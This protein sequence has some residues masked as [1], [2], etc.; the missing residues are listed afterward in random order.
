[1]TPPIWDHAVPL[2]DDWRRSGFVIPDRALREQL[3]YEISRAIKELLE[4]E[5]RIDRENSAHNE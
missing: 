4:L 5:E 1:M 2:A 3:K